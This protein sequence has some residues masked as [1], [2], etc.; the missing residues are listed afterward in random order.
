MEV[1][2]GYSVLNG[3]LQFIGEA[4][5]NSDKSWV[6]QLTKNMYGLKQASHNWYNRL[7][8]ELLSIGFIQSKIDKCLF[9]RHDCV[10]VIYV[11]DC[12]LFSAHDTVLDGIL[13]HLHK[14]FKI[15][16]EADIGAY[17][18][19]DIRRTAEGHM[20][21]TRPGLI[22]KV[23]SICGLE[24]ESNEHR[25]PADCILQAISSQAEPRQL[26]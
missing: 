2:A 22:N 16:S 1:P 26:A 7:Q 13:A 19:L 3:M 17:V 12:L 4:N 18:G 25:T 6:L 15:T 24:N 8:E 9:M 14:S 20:E 23:I 5:R 11:D 21:I 10:I